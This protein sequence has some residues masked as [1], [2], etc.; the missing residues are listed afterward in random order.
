[1]NYVFFCQKRA[2]TCNEKVV[3]IY[4]SEALIELESC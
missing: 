4:S 1:M 2:E 3:I